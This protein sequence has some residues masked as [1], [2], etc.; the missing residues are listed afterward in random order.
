MDNDLEANV[1]EYMLWN[2]LHRLRYR[3]FKTSTDGKPL[4]F[5]TLDVNEDPRE[6]WNHVRTFGYQWRTVDYKVPY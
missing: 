4:Y 6:D 1:H 3:Y 2:G 5:V